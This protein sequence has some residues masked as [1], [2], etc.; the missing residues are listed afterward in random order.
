MTLPDT[1]SFSNKHP[2]LTVMVVELLL[3][4]AV[5]AAGAYATL[6]QLPYTSPV[7]IAF[8]PIALALLFYMK[9]KKRWAHYGFRSLS[10]LHAPDW[11]DYAPL[12]VVLVILSIRAFR[13]FRYPK[14]DFSC[15]SRCSSPSW[16]RQYTGD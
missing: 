2:V 11:I 6:K 14:P 13:T 8:I 1:E 12:L 4:L 16:R 10:T 7:L 3:L 5:F 9:L 15:S